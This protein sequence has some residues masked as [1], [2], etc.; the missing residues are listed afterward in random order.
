MTRILRLS[1]DSAGRTVRFLSGLVDLP[2]GKDTIWVTVT[3]TGSF[4]DPRYGRFEISRDMLMSMVRNFDARVLGQDVFLDVEHKPADG[5]AAK[6]LRLAVEGDRLRAQVQLTPFGIAAIRERGFRYL[7]AEYVENWQDNELGQTHG[8]VLLGAALTVRPVI[9][10]LDP[11]QLSCVTDANTPTLIHPELARTLLSEAHDI[12]NKYLQKLLAQLATLKLSEDHLAAL[13]QAATVALSAVTD[14]A[15]GDKVIA[16]F[17]AVARKLAEAAPGTTVQLSINAP[18]PGADEIASQVQ[19]ALAEQVSS[20]RKL[21]DTLNSN[22]K[23]LSDLIGA[24]AGLGDDVKKSLSEGALALVTADM[25]TE[26]IQQLATVQIA[27]GHQIMAART[28]SAMGYAPAGSPRINVPDEGAIKLSSLYHDNLKRTVRGADGLGLVADDKLAPFARLVLSEF[29]RLNGQAIEAERVMLSEGTS[30]ANTS[31]PI[32]FQREVI[33]EA[34]HDLNV[35]ALVQTLT[36]FTATQT[37]LIP[38]E[39]RD[40][41]ALG[42]GVVYEGQGIPFASISQRSDSAY[43]TPMKI[44]ISIT[45]EVTH[46]TRSS[47]I[48]WD[49]LARNI[50]SAATVLRELIAR[51][52]CNEL[53][54]ASDRYLAL[55]VSNES[56]TSQLDGNKHTFKTAQFPIVRP[57]Q[58]R[59]VRG[60][61]IGDPENPITLTLNSVMILPWN[62]TGKQPAGTYYRVLSY[63]LGHIQLVDASGSPVTPASTGTNTISY[64]MATNVVR[65]NIDV[66]DGSTLELTLNK[67]LQAFGSRKAMLSSQRFVQPDFSL[68]SPTLNDAISNAEQFITERKRNGADTSTQGDLLTVKGVP[69]YGTNAPGVDLGDERILIGQKGLL[70]YTIAKPFTMG[71][72]FELTQDGHAIGKRAAYGEEY[73]AIHVP[74]P[75]V[76]RL[77][78]VL[79]YSAANR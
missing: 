48:N 29:D 5:A 39:E 52:I 35:L 76:G 72:P 16:E 42:D 11:I 46:F 51:R 67:V 75:V 33:R 34:L 68:M 3:R 15:T 43:I 71:E 13:K 30:M 59:D 4:S 60:D 63:N 66:A 78:S 79:V 2:E 54:R 41:A 74:K 38:Y 20:A 18:A 55:T 14:D 58:A 26:Q 23:Q 37:T 19:K 50:E 40:T 36:D 7:S 10:R 25:S 62:G 56:F 70:G 47:G 31:L 61:A 24:A 77:T 45:N 64:S 8:P 65:V 44:A 28:L 1:Q 69:A 22:R 32:G 53:Q 6:V 12:M 17:E 57:F 49:A 21:S 27:A 73:N 9:K